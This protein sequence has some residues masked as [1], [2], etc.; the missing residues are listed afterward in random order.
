MSTLNSKEEVK[1]K[2]N[3]NANVEYGEPSYVRF[4][5]HP[6]IASNETCSGVHIGNLTGDEVT[7]FD[8]LAERA[9][10]ILAKMDKYV[11]SGD[12]EGVELVD[13]L[14]ISDGNY[15]LCLDTDG[16]VEH[17]DSAVLQELLDIIEL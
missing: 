8:E 1:A 4:I 10:E 2:F 15:R 16:N 6:V 14:V 7:V 11:E 5:V 3:I 17:K 9:D 13:L 12:H